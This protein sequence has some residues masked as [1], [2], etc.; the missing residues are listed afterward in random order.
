MAGLVMA[1][2]GTA[3][4][5]K[6][7]K[8]LESVLMGTWPSN[9]RQT[10]GEDRTKRRTTPIGKGRARD[11]GVNCVLPFLH[12]RARL[13]DDASL[14]HLSLEAYRSFPSL[15]ENELTR[16][17]KQQLLSPLYQGNNDKSG[18]DGASAGMEWTR[19]VGNAR[20]QQGLIHLHHLIASPGTSS[21]GKPG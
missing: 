19:I 6:G 12:A 13:C 5:N 21:V 4:G 18:G 1:W 14:A 3:R 7:W 17:M 20:R 8:T 10:S 15:Q 2:P 16:E 9:T 11:I